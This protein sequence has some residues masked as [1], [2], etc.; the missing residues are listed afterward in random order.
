MNF[1]KA[2]RNFLAEVQISQRK[3]EKCSGLKLMLKDFD[4]TPR[5]LCALRETPLVPACPG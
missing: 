2:A 5:S 1:L 4:L 3:A